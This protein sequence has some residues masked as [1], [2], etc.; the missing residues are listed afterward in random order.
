MLGLFGKIYG[1]SLA[2]PCAPRVHFGADKSGCFVSALHKKNGGR[3][4]INRFRTKGGVTPV[5]PPVPGF[6]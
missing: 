4:S 1:G 6:F 3:G 2:P 5:P